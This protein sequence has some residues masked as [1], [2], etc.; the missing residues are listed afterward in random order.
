[1]EKV[2]GAK[3]MNEVAMFGV[4]HSLGAKLHILLGYGHHHHTSRVN[5]DTALVG[6]HCWFEPFIHDRA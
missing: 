4:G 5:I 3:L 1:V 6:C 2:Y